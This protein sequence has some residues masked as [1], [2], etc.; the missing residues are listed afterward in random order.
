MFKVSKRFLFFSC[1][2]MMLFICGCAS[3][4]LHESA[5]EGNLAKIKKHLEKGGDVNAKDTAGLSLLH[6][7]AFGGNIEVVTLLV[8]KGADINAQLGGT[9]PLHIAAEKGHYDTVE[10]LI[11]KGAKVN[12][13]NYNQIGRASCRER[14]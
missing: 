6:W 7:A 11:A 10:L 3:S 13:E 14:V 1:C 9:T 4:N 8:E 12:V 2:L 5:K